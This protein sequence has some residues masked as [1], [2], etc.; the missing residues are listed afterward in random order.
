MFNG[1]GFG[2]NATLSGGATIDGPS[3]EVLPLGYGAGMSGGG[4][5]SQ[6]MS[7]IM[8]DFTNQDDDM[9]DAPTLGVPKDS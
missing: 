9:P 3:G 2:G 5:S 1:G 4:Q 7:S 8:K 6:D